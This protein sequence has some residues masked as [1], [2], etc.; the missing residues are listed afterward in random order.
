M[1]CRLPVRASIEKKIPKQ[2]LR[3]L[4][5]DEH[6]IQSMHDLGFNVYLVDS[7]E[8]GLGQKYSLDS[9]DYIYASVPENNS[10]DDCEDTNECNGNELDEDSS[11][12]WRSIPSDSASVNAES[13]L[14]SRNSRSQ[15]KKSNRDHL[16][17]S[18]SSQNK[19]NFEE[20]L[21][22]RQYHQIDSNFFTPKFS[23]LDKAS[24]KKKRSSSHKK[25]PETSPFSDF[26]PYFPP[27]NYAAREKPQHLEPT[28]DPN[29]L[30]SFRDL[31]ANAG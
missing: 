16:I 4:D 8:L 10:Y 25:H 26:Q 1:K 7:A 2:L 5:H 28:Y 6:S 15:F 22:E 17:D 18:E 24:S 19:N 27:V 21:E 31:W 29:N 9:T 12:S 3:Q 30:N 20:N 13:E 23:H 14:E 11:K